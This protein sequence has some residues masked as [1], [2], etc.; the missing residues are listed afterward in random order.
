MP[1]PRMV[2]RNAARPRRLSPPT[3]KQIAKESGGYLALR[4]GVPMSNIGSTV[5]LGH[6]MFWD[7]FLGVTDS[8][9][10]PVN[11]YSLSSDS[12]FD[13]RHSAVPVPEPSAPLMMLVGLG[14]VG[15]LARRRLLG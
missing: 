9:G 4:N 10:S 5:D 14:L 2:P 15:G 3:R 1:R 13:Y 6:T 12:G 11:D 7:G 8:S